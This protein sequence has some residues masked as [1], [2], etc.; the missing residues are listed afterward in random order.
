MDYVVDPS[1]DEPIMLLSQ[2]IGL[3]EE[4]N[5][6]VDSSLFQQ[7]LL[8]L[9]AMGKKRIKIYINSGGGDVDGGM[10][11][12]HAILQ[13]KTKVDTYCVFMACSIAAVIFECG[14]VR[15]MS[16]YSLLMFHS[17]YRKGDQ[18]GAPDPVVTLFRQSYAKA[19]AERSGQDIAMI[20]KMLDK[21]TWMDA[22]T[23]V[24][25]GFADKIQDTADY[26]NKRITVQ[27]TTAAERSNPALLYKKGSQIL[28][29]IFTQKNNMKKIAA[30]LNLQ[31][32]ASEDAIVK[33]ITALVKENA[34]IKAKADMD[35]D[36]ME[37]MKKKL[38]KAEKDCDDMKAKI[39]GMEDAEAKVKAESDAEGLKVKEEKAKALVASHDKAGRIKYTTET[40]AKV[41][42]FFEKQATEDY[43]GTEEVLNGMT[44][45]KTSIKIPDLEKT[46]QGEAGTKIAASAAYKMHEIAAK[47]KQK[48]G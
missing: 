30:V 32:E 15:Y 10:A 28:A 18:E 20:D 40:K 34:T 5:M 17:P 2:H 36:D 3:D 7:S 39:K 11:I 16:D 47:H 4:G 9:D 27:K 43:E 12:C 42:A 22:E 44:I 6:G 1:A 48:I 25:T 8:Q 45:N 29:S 33:G 19:V 37:A 13:T 46:L 23:A 14:A 26:N 35:D 21:D 31:D 41:I 38:A 24:K